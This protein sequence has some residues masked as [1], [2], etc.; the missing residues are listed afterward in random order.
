[1]RRI[2]N[3]TQYEF[4]VH[5]QPME[6][7]HHRR[8][9]SSSA[10]RRSSSS[11]TSSASLFAGKKAGRTRGRRTRS[12]GRRPRRRRTATSGAT[13]PTVYRGPYE[14]SSPVVDRGLPAAGAGW[15]R[16]PARAVA[17]TDA[18]RTEGREHATWA[19]AGRIGWRAHGRGDVRPPLR[20]RAGHQH[21][22]R[23]WPCPTGRCRSA[24]I[25]F[26]SP[27]GWWAASSSSTV[28]GCR[29]AGRAP[30]AGARRA[31]GLRRAAAGGCVRLG[32][33]AVVAGVAAGRLGGL[34]CSL[35]RWPSR[36][37]T[38]A[39]PRCSSASWSRSPWSPAARGGAPAV[40]ATGRRA[41]WSRRGDCRRR[42]LR[43]ARP[44]RVHH[45][46]ARRAVGTW[47]RAGDHDGCPGRLALAVLRRARRPRPRLVGPGGGTLLVR[48]ARSW[49]S[50]PH[51][52][53]HERRGARRTA[54]RHRAAG[55][56]PGRGS[57]PL[58]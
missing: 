39:W 16:A 19:S 31:L 9:R 32:L 37:R 51:R 33:V 17:D 13:L 41:V 27:S 4:L 57:A 6:R 56:P 22:G 53:L 10:R 45:A 14:Y 11:S 40:V 43:T 50:A 18:P 55:P 12:S 2:Y 1:M 25:P 49:A 35:L 58:R 28:T 54:R 47:R 46:R 26:C 24:T 8:A 23:G 52:P 42:R 36:W 29:L 5:L 38:P 7:V 21:R 3:P 15:S 30:D 44:R 20:R 34:R 48:P